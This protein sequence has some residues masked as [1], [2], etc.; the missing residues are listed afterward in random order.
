MRISIIATLV[1]SAFISMN[2]GATDLLQVYQ[3]ALTNDPQYMSARA[4]RIWPLVSGESAID[5]SRIV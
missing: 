1:A 5:F 2:A 3:E 4:A